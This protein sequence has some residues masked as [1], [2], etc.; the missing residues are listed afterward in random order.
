MNFWQQKVAVVT[1]GSAG[2]GRHLAEELARRHA[3]VVIVGRDQDRLETAK[4]AIRL[5]HAE[6]QCMTVAADITQ[7]GEVDRLFTLTEQH[8]G[9]LDL[10]INCAGRSMRGRASETSLADFQNLLD[11]NTLAAIDCCQQALP[12]LRETRG[13][14]VNIG[15]LASRIATPNLGGYPVSKFAIAGYSEQLRRELADEGVHVLTVFPGPIARPDAGER[16]AD[17][18]ADLGEAAQR[19]GGTHLTAADP[20]TLSRRILRAAERR[21]AEWMPTKARIFCVLALLSPRLADR[22]VRKMT[23]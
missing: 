15:S 19:P 10:L 5:D 6:A 11:L 20:T 13:T 7:T 2:L 4:A 23:D 21:K 8:F 18:A 1:G 9:Q 14:I 3:R 12:A 16:Y 22:V 17:Q